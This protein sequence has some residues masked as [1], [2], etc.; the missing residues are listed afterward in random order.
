MLTILLLGLSLCSFAHAA[1]Y[2]IRPFQTDTY[3]DQRE[4]ICS[5]L[6]K[7]Q[8]YHSAGAE[9]RQADNFEVR[10]VRIDIDTQVEQVEVLQPVERSSSPDIFNLTMR[11]TE[12]FKR[13][14][15]NE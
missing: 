4:S 15:M 10:E 6:E 11:V 3:A 13:I 7:G 14:L 2:Q 1:D 8:L 9:Y 5:L 12:L